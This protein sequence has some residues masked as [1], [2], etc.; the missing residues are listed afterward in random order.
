MGDALLPH[1]PGPYPHAACEGMA[2]RVRRRVAPR[3]GGGD[4]AMAEGSGSGE[5]DATDKAQ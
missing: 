1:L 4:A 5:G 2:P 3:E